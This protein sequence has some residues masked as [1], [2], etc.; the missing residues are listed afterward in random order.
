MT[1]TE[2]RRS[3]VVKINSAT[4]SLKGGCF[5]KVSDVIKVLNEVKEKHGDLQVALY[6]D[7][8]C[9]HSPC[10]QFGV[11]YKIDEVVDMPDERLD[12]VF[13]SIA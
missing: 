3:C 9:S 8:A 7:G 13:I 5:L 12:D 4:S 2:T 6:N 10:L 11:A 1:H